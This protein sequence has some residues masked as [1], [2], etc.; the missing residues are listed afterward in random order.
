VSTAIQTVRP[1]GAVG[2]GTHNRHAAFAEVVYAILAPGAI[3][4]LWA[5]GPRFALGSSSSLRCQG[6]DPTTLQVPS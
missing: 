5:H 6:G 3:A 4:V 2:F 1:D